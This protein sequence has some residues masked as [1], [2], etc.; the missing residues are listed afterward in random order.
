VTLVAGSWEDSISAPGESDRIEPDED[1]GQG[2][3]T[4]KGEVLR[5]KGQHFYVRGS[6]GPASGK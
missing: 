6:D 4:I 1:T 2:I 5:I 3:E